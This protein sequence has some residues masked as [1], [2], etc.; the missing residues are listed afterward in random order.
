[1]Y[2]A[3]A[4]ANQKTNPDLAERFKP[5]ADSLAENETA[6]VKELND[7]QGFAQDLGGYYKPDSELAEKAMRPSSTFNNIIGAI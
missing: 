2:W 5:I 1:M 6:I 7:A 3:R 4:L